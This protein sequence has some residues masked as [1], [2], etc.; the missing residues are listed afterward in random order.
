[1]TALVLDASVAMK[2]AIPSAK[3]TLTAESLQLLKR[4]TDGDINFI[5]PDVF[6]A[7]IGNVMWKGVRQRRWPQAIAERATSEIRGQDFFTV[8][9]L[10]LLADAMK[11]AFVHDR[12]VYDCLYVALAIQ[13]KTEMITADERLANAL[14]ARLPVKWLG[15]FETGRE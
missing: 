11:I 9:S 4:Y 5:V 10:E 14:A 12:S 15:A 7:E 8:S 2:W 3:E 13:F 1:L 6:W